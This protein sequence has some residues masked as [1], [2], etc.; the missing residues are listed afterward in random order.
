M[1]VLSASPFAGGRCD[2]VA[3]AAAQG[4]RAA[5]CQPRVLC[6]RDYP[7]GPCRGCNACVET[8]ACVLSGDGFGPLVG[9]LDACDSCLLVS[10]VYFAGPPAQLKALFDRLQVL[11]AHRYA[12]KLGPDYPA[13]PTQ[14]RRPLFLA[15]LG[16]GGD[17]FGLEPLKACAH[18]ALRMLDL[19][20]ADT[21]PLMETDPGDELERARSL[22]AR[23]ARETLSRG[24]FS[25]PV[26]A[27]DLTSSL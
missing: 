7:I 24:A 22:G 27:A 16:S 18:S 1:V 15:A 8:G 9:E 10:P 3:Q 25:R 4:V 13:L 11:W 20:L 26:R 2:R 17:P 12:P 14:D 21:L 5:G 6:L 23:L 19:E